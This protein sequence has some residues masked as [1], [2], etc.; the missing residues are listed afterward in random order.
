MNDN[1]K[2]PS[3]IWTAIASVISGFVNS[4]VSLVKQ[5][6]HWAAAV[7]LG[8]VVAWGAGYLHSE[9]KSDPQV[10]ALSAA[11]KGLA[12]KSDIAELKAM[13]A[14]LLTDKPD[15]PAVST[16]SVKPKRPPQP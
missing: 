15:K 10:S 2:A 1:A 14:T 8:L 4:V 12:S 11:V 16:G 7:F 9:S 6:P 5:L 3:A 13:V